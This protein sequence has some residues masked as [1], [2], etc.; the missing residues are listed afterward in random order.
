MG[1]EMSNLPNHDLNTAAKGPRDFDPSTPASVRSATWARIRHFTGLDRA[2]GFTV[3]ARGWSTL[4]GVVTVLLI[5]RFLSPAEQGYYYT[6]SSL[7]ALQI[8]FELGFSFVILQLAAHERA[9]LHILAT[10]EISGEFVAH[11][12]LASVL[13]KSVRWYSVAALI[14][15]VSLLP[16]GFYFFSVHQHAAENVVWKL[17]WICV[18]LAAT[19]TFQMDPVFSFL[20][21]C[22]LVSDVAHMR[23]GQAAA[24]SLLA[25]AA[26]VLHHG[27][28]APAMVITGQVMVGGVFLLS[29]RSLLLPLLRRK[30]GPNAIGWRRE[31]WPFQWRIAVSWFCGYFIFQLFNPVLFAYQGAAAAGRMG[32]SLSIATALSAVALAWM[33]TKASPFGNMIALGDFASLD[34]IFFRTLVQSSILFVFGGMILL[35]ALVIVEHRLPH[36]ASR[37]LSAPIFA[38]LLLT[39]LLN[40]IIFSEALYL[41]AHKKEPFLFLSILVAILTGSSTLVTGKLWGADGVAIGYF[42]CSGVFGSAYGTFIFVTLRRKWHKFKLSASVEEPTTAGF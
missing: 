30:T 33:S 28:F 20:E 39:A 24:G 3:L 34:R 27:L 11:S 40:H 8:V 16:A 22:G 25:W 38:L 14:M 26:L 5:A 41:R 35:T 6:F 18:V 31:I 37:V 7:V 23:F 9:Q 36:L 29:K 1:G 4:A 19:F 15:A 21:G 10:G 32:M 17:P 42:L 2:I 12:R 13:Q